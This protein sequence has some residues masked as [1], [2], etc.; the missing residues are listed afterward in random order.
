M[1]KIKV[2][3]ISTVT[4]TGNIE[5]LNG[6]NIVSN[7]TGYFGLPKGSS[8]SRPS[9]APLGATRYNTDTETIESWNGISWVGVKGGEVGGETNPIKYGPS[10]VPPS[11]QQDGYFYYD[12]NGKSVQM[13]TTFASNGPGG[14]PSDIT[15]SGWCLFSAS[16]LRD[17]GLS[18]SDL[19]LYNMTDAGTSWQDTATNGIIRSWRLRLPSWTTGISIQ[20][21]VITQVNGPDGRNTG[22]SV[23]DTNLWNASQGNSIN[24]GSNYAMLHV[25][26]GSGASNILRLYKNSNGGVWDVESPPNPINLNWTNGGTSGGNFNHHDSFTSTVSGDPKYLVKSSSDGGSERYYINDFLIWIR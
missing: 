10:S 19:Q 14:S 9:T 3:S 11:Q 13:Y 15:S 12:W 4:G 16:T 17:F 7:T 8:D 23:S 24:L 5:L 20:E 18:L 21:F 2:D 1:S 26:V 25:W 6:A 22:S